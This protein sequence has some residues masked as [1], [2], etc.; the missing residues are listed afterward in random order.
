MDPLILA[1]QAA[2]LASQKKAG[3][4]LVLDL[5]GKSDVCTHM[6]ICSGQNDKQTVAIA[7]SIEDEF[8]AHF[9]MRPLAVEGKQN[10]QWIL[11]DYGSTIIH[12]FYEAIRDYYALENLFPDAKFLSFRE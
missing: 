5:D 2:L 1:K 9:A 10:G 8:K 4:I 7:Q 11:L 12:I 6:M 3:R